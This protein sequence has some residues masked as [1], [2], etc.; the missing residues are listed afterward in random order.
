MENIVIK[1]KKYEIVKE[2]IRKDDH[3]SYE[4]K[5]KDKKFFIKKY[6]SFE[7]FDFEI[8]SYKDFKNYG[9]RNPKLLKKDKKELT[10][11]YEY[12]DG[13][14]ALDAIANNT[15]DDFWFEQLFL[16]YKFARFSKI[17]INYLPECYKM[18][19]GELYYM[20]HY[21]FLQDSKKNLENYGIDFWLY[22]DK[23][24]EYLKKFGYQIDK[25]RIISKTELNKK[26]VLLSIMKW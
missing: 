8:K 15:I 10:V 25:K 24:A 1:R 6:N 26:I 4:C 23:C 22:G 2:V 17:D 18:Y 19:K 3:I 14:N 11:V 16:I 13:I 9:I 12:I 20:N 21:Y 5:I 7:D